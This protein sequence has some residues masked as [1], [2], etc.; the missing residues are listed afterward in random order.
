MTLVRR[1]ARP[2]LA[3]MFIMGGVDAFRHPATK[4]PAAGPLVE[5]LAGPLHLP[6]DTELL[7][8]AN[9]L[10]MVT[11]GGLLAT[12]R[13]PRL[14]SLVLAGTLVPAT[15]AGHRFWQEQDEATRKQQRTQ[16]FKN[17]SMLGGLLLGVV[18]TEG[19]PSL[20]YRAK[21]AGRD[22]ERA[23]TTTRKQARRAARSAR[24]EARRTVAQAH[25]ALT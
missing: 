8:R 22:V 5:K 18:D 24:R 7:V 3:S 12:G 1:I 4:A 20:T 10:A 2:M 15:I 16:F 13:V 19:R 6:E 9:G 11:A 21:A 14:A 25:D 23:A 17:V